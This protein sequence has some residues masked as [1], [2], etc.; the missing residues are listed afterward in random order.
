MNHQQVQ[1]LATFVLL[2]GCRSVPKVAPGPAA[3]N[4][5]A[6]YIRLFNEGQ[7]AQALSFYDGDF[8]AERVQIPRAPQDDVQL[9][10]QA[11]AALLRRCDLR[12]RSVISTER[13]GVDSFLLTATFNDSLGR[14]F[15]AEPCC[16]SGVVVGE[17]AWQFDVHKVGDGY[18]IGKLPL[19]FP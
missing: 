1:V 18:R 11:C 12:L 14:H 9:I 10:A 16:D 8:H 4:T 19:Y 2:L 3:N 5:L 13:V 6:T 7:F 17:S 15:I